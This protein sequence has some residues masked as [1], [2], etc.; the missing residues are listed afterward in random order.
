MRWAA[1]AAV[2]LLMTVVAPIQAAPRS[3]IVT[4]DYSYEFSG[5]VSRVELSGRAGD[6]PSGRVMYASAFTTFGGPVACVNVIGSDAW[7]AGPITFGGSGIEGYDGWAVRVH[8]GGTPGRTGDSAITFIDTPESAAEIC[9]SGTADY[10][11][12]MVP[13][14]GGNLVVHPAN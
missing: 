1:P 8:D 10:D 3:S 14:V 9:A 13:V 11:A 12:F 5:R 7:L 4:G 2:V 6:P